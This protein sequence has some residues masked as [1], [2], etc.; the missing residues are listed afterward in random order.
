MGR[1]RVLLI[2][3][4]ITSCG[5]HKAWPGCCLLFMERTI[6]RSGW[7]HVWFFCFLFL[8]L[9]S[10][11]LA[12]VW[13]FWARRTYSTIPVSLVVML[14]DTAGCG[15]GTLRKMVDSLLLGREM[16]QPHPSGLH[17][18]NATQK[19]GSDEWDPGS[20]HLSG[21]GFSSWE[22]RSKHSGVLPP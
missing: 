13:E 3:T 2:Q 16:I 1:S 15:R 8:S 17:T 20:C 10:W 4:Y 12:E 21:L 14:A 5:C 6:F 9:T 7:I 11:M 22:G 19:H 18:G